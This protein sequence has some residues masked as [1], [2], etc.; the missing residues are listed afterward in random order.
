MHVIVNYSS[1]SNSKNTMT[2]FGDFGCACVKCM[3]FFCQVIV[4]ISFYY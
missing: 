2:Q 1:A 3:G 4:I